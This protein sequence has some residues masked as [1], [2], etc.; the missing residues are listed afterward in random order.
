MILPRIQKLNLTIFIR[1]CY[2]GIVMHI[3]LAETDHAGYSLSA[4]DR[5]WCI[6][7]GFDLK[8]NLPRKA[9]LGTFEYQYKEDTSWPKRFYR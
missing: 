5:H 7:H 4:F 2:N 6:S 8:P 9:G 3:V 1:C